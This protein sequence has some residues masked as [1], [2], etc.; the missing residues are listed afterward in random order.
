M[1]LSGQMTA[2]EAHPV[3]ASGL[4]I[5]VV[6]YPLL[7][8][9][10]DSASTS[11]GHEATQTPQ[12]LQRSLSTTIVP[13]IFAITFPVKFLQIYEFFRARIYFRKKIHLLRTKSAIRRIRKRFK[14]KKIGKKKILS[15]FSPSFVDSSILRDTSRASVGSRAV[16]FSRF[17]TGKVWPGRVMAKRNS[18][19]QTKLS[20]DG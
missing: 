8:T 16:H 15:D 14:D 20:S 4:A 12:P 2:H 10:T 5:R 11:H 19:N 17:S 3:Q 9:S 13:L 6:G 18:A 7:F 1:Q